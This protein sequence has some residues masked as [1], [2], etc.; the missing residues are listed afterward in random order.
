MKDDKTGEFIKPPPIWDEIRGSASESPHNLDQYMSA[1]E[2]L[3]CVYKYVS[4]CSKFVL[5][6]S[7]N[8]ICMIMS[9]IICLFV[10]YLQ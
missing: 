3:R 1:D 6:Y 8:V 10:K 5:C 2:S 7:K 4:V 9:N